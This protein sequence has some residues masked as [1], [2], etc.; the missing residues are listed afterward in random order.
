MKGRK[1]SKENNL[2]A[3]VEYKGI[4]VWAEKRVQLVQQELKAR[5]VDQVMEQR[6]V[7]R[8]GLRNRK[9]REQNNC[10]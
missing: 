4:K 6:H 3:N 5:L 2:K 10:E 7:L 8:K 9:R 1:E